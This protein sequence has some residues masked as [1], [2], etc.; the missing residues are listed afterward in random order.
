MSR[1]LYSK[2]GIVYSN[3][4]KCEINV[5][6]NRK[7]VLKFRIQLIICEKNHNVGLNQF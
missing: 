5:L 1:Y 7:I 3:L 2:I 6:K 4:G